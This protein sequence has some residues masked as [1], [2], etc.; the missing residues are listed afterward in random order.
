[1][2]SSDTMVV[3]DFSKGSLNRGDAAAQDTRKDRKDPEWL[4]IVD[5]TREVVV[6]GIPFIAEE[7]ETVD[8]FTARWKDYLRAVH[9]VLD[10]GLPQDYAALSLH[11]QRNVIG[12]RDR[13]LAYGLTM[14]HLEN[15]LYDEARVPKNDGKN[16]S[17]PYRDILSQPVPIE[18]KGPRFV[19]STIRQGCDYIEREY[20]DGSTVRVTKEGVVIG[21][22][23]KADEKE[24]EG[25]GEGTPKP[26]AQETPAAVDAVPQRAAPLVSDNS[27]E[28]E[29]R[30]CYLQERVEE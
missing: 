17:V 29:S 23:K 11:D 26:A 10:P 13:T 22:F 27:L 16:G 7:G 3:H 21:T 5:P 8:T 12:R 28:L 2:I 25:K 9:D 18:E 14:L 6:L 1:M 24:G 20:A 19:R 4:T 30:V 15:L